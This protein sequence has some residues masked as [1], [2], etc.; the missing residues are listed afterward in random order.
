MNAVIIVPTV[1]VAVPSRNHYSVSCIS[2]SYCFQSTVAQ[3]SI[4]GGAHTCSTMLAPE[5]LWA[6]QYACLDSLYDDVSQRAGYGA[7]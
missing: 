4:K 2:I 1:C 5:L 7:S 6:V 3:T